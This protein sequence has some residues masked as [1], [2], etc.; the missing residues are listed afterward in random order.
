VSLSPYS[1]SDAMNIFFL[2]YKK[3]VFNIL[4]DKIKT[5]KYLKDVCPA[6][7]SVIEFYFS[8]DKF[9]SG[10]ESDK[11]KA[12]KG[13]LLLAKKV[14]QILNKCC[15]SLYQ[16]DLQFVKYEVVSIHPKVNFN[17]TVYILQ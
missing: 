11:F 5:L 8:A 6:Y 10:I 13:T 14:L 9:I 15:H 4:L 3:S 16:I 12:I 17:Q 1:Q 7:W 2:Y